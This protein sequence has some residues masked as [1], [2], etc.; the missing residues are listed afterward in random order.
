MVGPFILEAVD[1]DHAEKLGRFRSKLPP[2]EGF[3]QYI[4][5]VLVGGDPHD[6]KQTHRDVLTDRV[7]QH[8]EVFRLLDS[9]R[10]VT[11]G[12]DRRGIVF[13]GNCL[14]R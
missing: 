3:R 9:R 7:H 13:E 12:L 10:D 4:R 5:D 14:R 11:G 8:D 1:F 6:F 2:I